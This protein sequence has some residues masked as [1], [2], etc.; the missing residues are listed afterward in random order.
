MATLTRVTRLPGIVAKPQYGTIPL[1]PPSAP[2]AVRNLAVTSITHNGATVLF[3]A[4]ATGGAPTGWRARVAT[5]LSGPWSDAIIITASPAVVP[6]TAPETTYLI[7]IAAINVTGQGPWSAPVSATTAQAPQPPGA[8]TTLVASAIRR[9]AFVASWSDPVGGSAPTSAALR[10][11]PQGATAWTTMPGFAKGAT[12]T[13][14][15]AGTAYEW[16]VQLANDAGPGAWSALA[17]TTTTAEFA[18]PAVANLADWRNMMETPEAGRKNWVTGV[19]GEMVGS[20]VMEAGGTKVTSWSAYYKGVPEQATQTFYVVTRFLA[21]ITGSGD[22]PVVIGSRVSNAEI[23]L[24]IYTAG[25]SPGPSS[26]P[27]RLYAGFTDGTSVAAG[28]P[29]GVSVDLSQPTILR[30]QCRSGTDVSF[31]DISHNLIGAPVSIST[32]TRLLSSVQPLFYGSNSVSAYSGS[33]VLYTVVVVN[34]VPTS[35]EDAAIVAAIRAEMAYWSV[36]EAAAAA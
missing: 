31:S 27:L 7:E 8:A 6:L 24:T 32:K 5:S 1:A 35:A 13:A 14:L 26:V 4:P 17:A 30:T 3:D 34:G 19:A 33:C 36:A 9:T 16:Q 23:G 29:G 28:P 18:V 12:L 20:P 22:R 10:Y 11:R 2:G 25:T 21:P 15:T